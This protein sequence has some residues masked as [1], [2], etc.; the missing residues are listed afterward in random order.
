MDKQ[1]I[2]LLKAILWLEL[3]DKFKNESAKQVCYACAANT[4]AGTT[5]IS[6]I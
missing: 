6:L 2:Q 5:V 4:L 3:A 1:E